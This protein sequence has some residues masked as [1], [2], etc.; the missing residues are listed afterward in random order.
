MEGGN[1]RSASQRKEPDKI[2]IPDLALTM[3]AMSLSEPGLCRIQG[4]QEIKQEQLDF[5]CSLIMKVANTGGSSRSLSQKSVEDAMARAWKDKYHGISQVSSSVFL[6]H[7]KSQEDMVSIYI[8]QPWIANSE[9]LL[10]DWFDSSMNATSSS[11]FR[12]DSILVTVRAYGIPRN[13]R[14]ISLLKNILNQVGEV[15][16]FHILQETNL[17]AKQDYIWG[18]AKLKVDNPIKDRAALS[19]NDNSSA[20]SYLHYEKI[21]RICLFCGIMFHNTQDCKLRNNLISERLKNRQSSADIPEQRYGQWV[22]DENLIP[23]DLIQSARMGDQDTSQG[24]NVILQRLRQMFAEDLKGKSKVMENHSLLPAQLRIQDNQKSPAVR[25]N[26]QDVL[27]SSNYEVST[28]HQHKKEGRLLLTGDT[29]QD[30]RHNISPQDSTQPVINTIAEQH[31]GQ[32]STHQGRAQP[33]ESENTETGFES[34]YIHVNPTAR[35]SQPINIYQNPATGTVFLDSVERPSNAKRAAPSLEEQNQPS[36][37]KPMASHGS[38]MYMQDLNT[39][40]A[41]SE[42]QLRPSIPEC[43]KRDTPSFNTSLPLA[44]NADLMNKAL[45]IQIMTDG[46][47]ILGAAPTSP[48][49]FNATQINKFDS[50]A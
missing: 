46:T 8:K 21:K 45:N 11:D 38:H 34:T 25:D 14:S 6:A 7:F 5:S 16:D 32:N 13:K 33:N 28:E 3:Q 50:K 49:F 37:K 36:A 26:Y 1:Q 20:I 41:N 24:G 48:S 19:F 10:V 18:T 31:K 29:G 4:N 42:S 9:N 2:G 39:Q 30:D 40:I 43:V 23:T 44:Q 27:R 17:F 35:P 12:F 47:G 22:V 15:S